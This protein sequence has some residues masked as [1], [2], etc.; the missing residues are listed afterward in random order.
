MN[1]QQMTYITYLENKLP[2][3]ADIKSYTDNHFN[4]RKKL[5]SVSAG[6]IRGVEGLAKPG[7]DI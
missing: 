5:D 3:E 1:D 2:C 4:C 6:G 7:M